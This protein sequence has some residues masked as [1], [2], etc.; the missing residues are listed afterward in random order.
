M[1]QTTHRL[2]PVSFLALLLF[3][4]LFIDSGE[5]DQWRIINEAKQFAHVVLFAL[6]GYRVSF[7]YRFSQ[8]RF[9]TKFFLILA[10]GSGLGF[11]TEGI[12]YFIGRDFELQDIIRDVIGC[13]VGF[14]IH[15]AITQPKLRHSFAV[16]I[17]VLIGVG[18]QDLWIELMDEMDM[19]SDYALLGD[20]ETPF[21]WTRWQPISATLTQSDQ[22]SFAGHYSLRVDLKPAKFSGVQLTEFN[23]NW[24]GYQSLEMHVYNDDGT[25]R[26]F[27]IKIY[28]R[29]HQQNG[30][31]HNDR[32]NHG[33]LLQPGWNTIVISMRDLR[34]APSE[35]VMN[36]TEIAALEIF[37]TDLHYP[38]R[39]YLDELRL[40]RGSDQLG[41]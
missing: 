16:A 2:W 21:Q 26:E 40:L 7:N 27:F 3:S 9:Q 24:N 33:V 19:S 38:M 14:A 28:D 5:S 41:H 17:V 39:I 6:I 23:S 34:Y 18:G 36:L 15:I 20:F 4:L 1:T 35:R 29:W 25:T 31:L 11:V 8:Q 37:T 13:L 30:Y 32:F 10:L 12:Q 22:E